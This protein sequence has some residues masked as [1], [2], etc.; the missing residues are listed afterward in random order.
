MAIEIYSGNF[1]TKE[2]NHLLKRTLF[3]AKR[4]DISSLIGQ[5]VTQAVDLLLK[6][7]PL[8]NPPINNYNDTGYTDANVPAGQT[9][10]NAVYTDGTANSRRVT[11][12]KAWW[13]GQM[14][15][16]PIS[17][18]EKMTLFWHNHFSIEADTVDDARY[19]YKH[20]N[21]LRSFALGNFKTLVKQVTID[22]A[23]LKYLNG[24]AS[25][26]SAPDEN[27]GRELQELFTMGKG[28]D[29]KY[30]E[31]DVKAAARLLTGYK[32]DSIAITSVFDPT[33]HDVADKQFSAF[34]SNKL[35]KGRTGVDG[36]KELDDLLDMLFAQAELSK[37][38]CRRL[39]RFFVYYDITADIEA[40]IISPL[41]DIFRSNNYEIK[42]VL[43]ALLTSSHFFLAQNRS[44]NIKAPI[45][46]VVGLAKEFEIV[47]PD[48]ADYVNAYY[49]WDYLRSTASNL[50]QNLADPPNVSGWPAYYQIPQFYE[51]WINSDTLPKRNI[52][53]DRFISTG[54]TRNGKKI[55][56]DAIAYTS[57]FSKPEDPNILVDEA[58]THLYTIDVSPEVRAFLKSILLS[59]Q[60][61]DSYWTTAWLDYKAAPTTM[62]TTIVLTRLQEFYK[63]I[64]NL[65]EYQLS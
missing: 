45:D 2:I 50:Q 20:N 58:L 16:Q 32:I 38:I 10:V 41:A 28:S 21:L 19:I 24:Y 65:E 35:I 46:F 17:I 23:M 7:L 27:Y 4:S 8:P 51:L 31:A 29:S 63:Y 30:T 18:T 6:D 48:A 15:A 9:W 54:Y 25:T 47:F 22:P 53:T 26:K 42:P 39:Y 5:S 59:N 64:M 61:T 37:Y 14:L 33:R 36:A 55:V 11:S 40:N 57:K 13:V 52:F 62:K 49:M 12:F 43:K 60:V 34:Y 44:C 1:G 3:G 56:I